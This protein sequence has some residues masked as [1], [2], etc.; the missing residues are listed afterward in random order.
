MNAAP[1]DLEAVALQGR[2]LNS[3]F[4]VRGVLTREI[5]QLIR[6]AKDS[7]DPLLFSPY[8][9]EL[10]LAE[11]FVTERILAHEL[12]PAGGDRS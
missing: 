10:K 4:Y 12:Y 5:R 11:N 3:L 7:P 6:L 1:M 8:V 9:R 2:S